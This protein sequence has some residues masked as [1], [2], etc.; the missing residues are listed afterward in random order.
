MTVSVLLFPTVKLTGFTCSV[1]EE[2][3]AGAKIRVV[4]IE[5]KSLVAVMVAV[6]ARVE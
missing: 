6:P 2:G 4:V 5:A 1:M 3:E